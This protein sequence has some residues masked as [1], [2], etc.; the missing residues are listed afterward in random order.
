[1]T[2][3]RPTRRRSDGE[4]T[5]ARIL[6]CAGVLFATNGYAETTSKAVAARARVDLASINYHFGN[7]DGL[8][9]TTL[10]E[11]HRRIFHLAELQQLADS[12]LPAMGKLEWIV[13]KLL[14]TATM[15][16]NWH[17]RM[18]VRELLAPTSHFQVLLA[19]VLPKFAVIREI[20]GEITG[21]PRDD[22]A[23]FR[24]FIST[25]APCTVLLLV[26]GNG[27]PG[28]TR[29]L[30]E[31]SRAD[32]TKHMVRFAM[33]GLKTISRDYSARAAR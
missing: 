30:L 16:P 27:A 5:R 9:K 6:E 1:M 14:S 21:I 15:N 19:E 13:E 24:C 22:P 2:T 23:L 31:A 28:P 3:R 12:N 18:V 7:R 11:A 32:L 29:D 20:F 8:Y 4:A 33:A 26:G 17:V 10:I 25:L